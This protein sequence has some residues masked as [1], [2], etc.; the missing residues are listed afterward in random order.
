MVP[1]FSISYRVFG[2]VGVLLQLDLER[3][4]RLMACLARFAK[5][6]EYVTL[7]HLTDNEKRAFDKESA[8]VQRRIDG[9][10]EIRNRC[11]VVFDVS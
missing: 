4:R 2:G 11:F 7:M 8:A 6:T 10:F 9:E 1:I 5:S 3:L